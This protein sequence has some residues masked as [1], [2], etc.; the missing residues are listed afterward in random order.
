MRSKV[1]TVLSVVA[2]VAFYLG[3][4]TLTHANASPIQVPARECISTPHARILCVY[5]A[6]RDVCRAAL[7]TSATCWWFTGSK[8][9][10]VF[11]WTGQVASS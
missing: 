2:S 3:V 5:R 1:F 6:P 9:Q 10:I 4:T 7:N 8:Q 11:R